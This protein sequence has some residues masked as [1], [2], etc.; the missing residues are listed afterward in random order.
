VVAAGGSPLGVSES[1]SYTEAL[2]R[3]S[4]LLLVAAAASGLTFRR[5]DV[6]S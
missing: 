2:I 6:A 1:L 4:A 5:R 3:V